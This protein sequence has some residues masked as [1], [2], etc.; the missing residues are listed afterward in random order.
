MDIILSK[1]TLEDVDVVD[2]LMKRHSKTLGF[3]PRKALQQFLSS[4]GTEHV[5]GAKDGDGQLVGYLLYAAYPDRFRIAHLC[6]SGK[7]QY[8]GIARRLVNRLKESA[9]TQGEIRLNC[10]RDFLAH[11][12]WPKLGFVPLGERPGRSRAGHPLTFWRLALTQ[13]DRFELFRAR[14]SDETLDVIID[15]QVL[16]DLHEADS[17]HNE[18]IQGTSVRFSRGVSHVADN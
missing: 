17:G 5:L 13:D 8:K 9:T 2:E 7:F 14:T 15:A 12:M 11:T 10:R 6:V 4:N 18:A 16:F 1:L 3:L